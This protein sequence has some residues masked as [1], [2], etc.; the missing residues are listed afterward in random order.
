MKL[1]ISRVNL[2]CMS[3]IFLAA[4]VMPIAA[5]AQ[6]TNFKV[7]DRVSASPL[8]L[9]DERYWRK[10]TVTEVHNF[11]KKA[12]SLTCEPETRGGSS[13]SFL[14]NEDW[15]RP[16]AAGADDADRG[17]TPAPRNNGGGGM[18]SIFRHGGGGGNGGNAGGTVQCFA[19]DAGAGAGGM[20]ST[21]RASVVHG[22]EH[23][24]HPGEDGRITVR[25]ES[26]T[27]GGSHAFR[28]LQDPPD[29]AGKTIYV[30]RANFTTCTDYN[31][32]IVYTKRTRQF[33]CF[34]KTGGQWDCEVVAAVNT[35]INDETNSL[36][37][38]R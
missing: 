16:L 33:A 26:F 27:L 21:F 5:W 12:Y 1:S 7:G 30:A 15:V 34:K 24:P 36:D 14:V 20:E 22:F 6:R 37:K 2:A 32:R 10:C 38:P 28:V 29:A 31:R 3:L 25:I 8:S 4:A 19:S 17:T 9:K 35:N 11:A 13:S 18:G 23:E